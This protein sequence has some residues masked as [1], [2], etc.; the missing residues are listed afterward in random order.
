VATA[1][2]FIGWLDNG[3]PVI[4]AHG[5]SRPSELIFAFGDASI[6]LLHTL[7]VGWRSKGDVRGNER[8][9]DEEQGEKTRHDSTRTSV[10]VKRALKEKEG[11]RW[12]PKTTKK[13]LKVEY[14]SSDTVHW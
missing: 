3:C 4:I 2:V 11:G 9:H 8:K 10:E 5:K 14:L 7:R 1:R 12:Q 6:Y 13:K